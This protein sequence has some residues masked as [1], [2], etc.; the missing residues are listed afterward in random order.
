MIIRWDNNRKMWMVY[1]QDITDQE[2]RKLGKENLLPRYY[3][4]TEFGDVYTYD[5]KELGDVVSRCH[6]CDISL[7]IITGTIGDVNEK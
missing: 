4:N 1:D 5:S 2:Y 6:Y 3:D 7:Q